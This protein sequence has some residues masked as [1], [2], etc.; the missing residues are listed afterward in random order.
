M[1]RAPVVKRRSRLFFIKQLTRDNPARA[2]IF[3]RQGYGN[4]PEY[5]LIP[6]ILKER[7][8]GKIWILRWAR[9]DQGKNKVREQLDLHQGGGLSIK[10][11][12]VS[13]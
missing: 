3:F 1:L 10:Y 8:D 7:S 13:G 9:G 6:D 11:Q 4:C 12:T 5:F 2:G